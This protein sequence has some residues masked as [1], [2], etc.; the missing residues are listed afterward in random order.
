M[1]TGLEK[2]LDNDTKMKVENGASMMGKCM[3]CMVKTIIDGLDLKLQI[4]EM[5]RMMELVRVSVLVKTRELVKMKELVRL[6][7]SM[8]MKRKLVDVRELV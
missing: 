8:P 1:K 4:R 3:W 7:E 2:E 6:K 5:V